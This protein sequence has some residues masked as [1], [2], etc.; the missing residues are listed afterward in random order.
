MRTLQ[1]DTEFRNSSEPHVTPVCAVVR[2]EGTFYYFW[3]PEDR[4]RFKTAWDAWMAEG[5]VIIAYY[6]SAE[7]RFMSSIGYTIASMLSWNWMDVYVM[8]RQLTHSFPDYKYGSKVVTDKK[9]GNKNWII[10]T[11]PPSDVPEEEEWIE[12]ENGELEHVEIDPHHSETGHGLADVIAHQYHIDIDTINKKL[13]RSLILNQETFSE[14]ERK[15]IIEYCASDV[16]HL[17]QLAIDLSSHISRLT[18]GHINVSHVIR[19]SRYMICCAEMENIGIPIDVKRAMTLGANFTAAS[20]DL[21]TECNLKYPFFV[22]KKSTK[23]EIE[24]GEKEYKWSENY[25]NFSDY[26]KLLGLDKLWPS[27]LKGKFKKDKETLKDFSADPA[28]MTL[29]VTKQTRNHLK[30]FRPEGWENIR[31]NIGSDDRVRV[32][33]SPFG[34]KTGRNQ[35]SVKNGYIFGMSTWLR[36]LINHPTLIVQGVDYAA[37]EILLQGYVSQDKSLLTAY[38][39]NDPYVWFGKCVHLFP[40]NI[41]RKKGVYYIDDKA[42]ENQKEHTTTRNILKA[43]LL[44]IGFGMGTKALSVR[45]T[46]AKIGSLNE[47]DKNILYGSMVSQDPDLKIQA[48]EILTKVRIVSG[49][50]P[51]HA[52]FVPEN[53]ASTYVNLHKKTFHTYWNWKYRIQDRYKYDGYLS[54]ADGWCLLAGERRQTTV[55]NFPVQG[56]GAVL[57]R[58]AIEKALLAGL[59]VIAP[60]HDCIYIVSEPDKA[61]EDIAVLDKVMHEA[62]V[63]ICGG[64]LIRTDKTECVTDWVNYTSAFTKDKQSEEF[65]KFGKYMNNGRSL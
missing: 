49:L 1:F 32:L 59:K 23:Q 16:V 2:I 38:S 29:W 64:D 41:E 9:T 18:N 4:E 48:A 17:L 44:G 10:T 35:P 47:E 20:N 13:M 55:S 14:V 24:K 42:C 54:L 62:V 34:S 45:L 53:R 6:A 5:L 56:T 12:N 27:T 19:L 25:K 61:K 36:P 30:Y 43:L 65:K 37:E 15:D 63:E 31:K 22:L 26:I 46:Q 58:I 33:L 52:N 8:W 21:I 60:L 3:F 28:I 57:L 39:S 50:E 7:A 51:E 40:E 11:P